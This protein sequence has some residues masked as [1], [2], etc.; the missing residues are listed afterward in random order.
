MQAVIQNAAMAAK[1]Q[2]EKMRLWPTGTTRW[3]RRAS[4]WVVGASAT[5]RWNVWNMPADLILCCEVDVVIYEQ[6]TQEVQTGIKQTPHTTSSS[7]RKGSVNRVLFTVGWLHCCTE[8]A[9]CMAWRLGFQISRHTTRTE[10]TK[11]G[12]GVASCL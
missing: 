2:A 7:R 11:A 4:T 6:M 3:E 1:A 8:V 10:D 5:G 9:Q 12:L